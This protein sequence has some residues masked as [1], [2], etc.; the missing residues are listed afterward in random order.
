MGSHRFTQSSMGTQS[1]I[2]YSGVPDF[3]VRLIYQQKT[4]L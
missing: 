4:A 1:R 2:A 3:L